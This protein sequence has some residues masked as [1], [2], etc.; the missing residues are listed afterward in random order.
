[1]LRTRVLTALVLLP[2]ALAAI[3]GL[4]SGT[5]T[6]VAA[7]LLLLGTWEFHRLADLRPLPGG[8]LLRIA[9]CGILLSLMANWPQ[10]APTQ[11]RY[12]TSQT[13][14]ANGLPSTWAARTTST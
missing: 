14:A 10:W 12:G 1:M 4:P 2:L 13:S 9:Q 3:F 6:W 5:F 8:G 7:A 11:L